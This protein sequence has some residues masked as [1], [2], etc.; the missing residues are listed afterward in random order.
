MD[1]CY[2][3]MKWLWSKKKTIFIRHVSNG[4]FITWNCVHYNYLIID[5]NDCILFNVILQIIIQYLTLY[6]IILL[7]HRFCII[8]SGTST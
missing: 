5:H 8:Y 1:V 4:V 7:I 2:S 3:S 6:I